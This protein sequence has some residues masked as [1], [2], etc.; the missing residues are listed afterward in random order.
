[1][2]GRSQ[3]LE[4]TRKQENSCGNV[5]KLSEEQRQIRREQL[6]AELIRLCILKKAQA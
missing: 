3:N 2:R 5:T 6:K 4:K 1:M